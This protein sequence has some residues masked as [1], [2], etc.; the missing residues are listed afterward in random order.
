MTEKMRAGRFYE[1]V[2]SLRIDRVPVQKLGFTDV[3]VGIDNLGR[4]NEAFLFPK[5]GNWC[6]LD[7]KKVRCDA[8]WF[9]DKDFNGIYEEEYYEVSRS[10]C[11]KSNG[12]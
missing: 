4:K 12:T 11:K 6:I 2:G 8:D 10:T 5:S 9:P 7:V 3:L 1:V